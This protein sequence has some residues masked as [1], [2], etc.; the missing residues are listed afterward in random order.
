[1]RFG[2]FSYQTVRKETPSSLDQYFLLKKK[3]LSSYI[4]SYSLG[5]LHGDS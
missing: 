4:T 3:K 1:M 5:N 2:I